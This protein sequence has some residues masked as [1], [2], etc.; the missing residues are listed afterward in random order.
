MRFRRA[1]ASPKLS[2]AS[3]GTPDSGYP[4]GLEALGQ[5]VTKPF[6][7]KVSHLMPE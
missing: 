4:L 6:G 7:Q 5:G 2:P 3:R 1:R